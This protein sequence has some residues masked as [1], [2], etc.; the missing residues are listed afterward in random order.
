MD[1]ITALVS[2]RLVSALVPFILLTHKLSD[3]FLALFSLKCPLQAHFS[4]PLSGTP[5]TMFISSTSYIFDAF[6]SQQEVFSSATSP[7]FFFFLAA[8][9]TDPFQQFSHHCWGLVL[10]NV[11]VIFKLFLN[12]LTDVGWTSGPDIVVG[13]QMQSEAKYSLDPWLSGC[14]NMFPNTSEDRWV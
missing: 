6:W 4:F 2:S 10:L 9:Y 14:I 8:H 7:V 1:V 3:S 13:M 12:V 11:T 5:V